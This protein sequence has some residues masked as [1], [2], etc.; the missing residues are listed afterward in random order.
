MRKTQFGFGLK[1]N[2]PLTL[3]AF[4]IGASLFWNGCAAADSASLDVSQYVH[5]SW[6]IREGFAAGFIETFAQTPDG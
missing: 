4:V 5:R 6:K 3:S 1:F 2:V